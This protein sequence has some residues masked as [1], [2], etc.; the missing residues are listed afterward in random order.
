MIPKSGNRFSEK[1]ML[2]RQAS[3]VDLTNE[4]LCGFPT[5]RRHAS[6]QDAQRDR[7]ECEGC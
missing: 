7:G 3:G 6:L 4:S 5:A 2:H 1:I